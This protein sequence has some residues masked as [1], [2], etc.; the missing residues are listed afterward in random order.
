MKSKFFKLLCA[1]ALAALGVSSNAAEGDVKESLKQYQ[2]AL[3]SAYASEVWV[4]LKDLQNNKPE[5]SANFAVTVEKDAQRA[6][7]KPLSK[8]D[9][10]GEDAGKTLPIDLITKPEFALPVGDSAVVT[11]KEKCGKADCYIVSS[12]GDA[13]GKGNI[14]FGATV[15]IDSATGR[16]VSSSVSLTGIPSVKQYTVKAQFTFDGDVIRLAESQERMS[17]SLMFIKYEYERH[18]KFSK[19]KRKA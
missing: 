10:A 19:W 12:K 17:A 16:P 1:L 5:V 6:S 11:G 8:A 7:L 4:G 18:Q 9:E 15:L 2:A 14:F 13:T 3:K